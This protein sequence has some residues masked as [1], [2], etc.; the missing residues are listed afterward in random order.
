MTREEMTEDMSPE[1]LE[2]FKR[3][4]DRDGPQD[5]CGGYDHEDSKYS[6]M[7]FFEMDSLDARRPFNLNE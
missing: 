3:A 1:E 2:E 7:D 6:D 5:I 4:E